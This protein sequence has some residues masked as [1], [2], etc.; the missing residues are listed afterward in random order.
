MDKTCNSC[1]DKQ[2]EFF[3]YPILCEDCWKN[4]GARISELV[5]KENLLEKYIKKY[6]ELVTTTTTVGTQ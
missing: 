4:M 1:H 2:A 3:Y 6:G 5:D